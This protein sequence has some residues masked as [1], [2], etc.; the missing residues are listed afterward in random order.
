MRVKI[1]WKVRIRQKEFLVSLFAALFLVVQS[2]GAT[3]GF[4]ID[5]FAELHTTFNA[6]LG[7]LVLLGVVIDPTTEK[8]SDSIQAQSYHK[9]KK[10]G[11]KTNDNHS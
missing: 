4:E 10:E 2:I 7:L 1:N 9:P 5:L 8:I 6:I 3:L 11:E